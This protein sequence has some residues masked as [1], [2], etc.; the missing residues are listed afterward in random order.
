MPAGWMVGSL[1]D[2]L[3]LYYKVMGKKSREDWGKEGD[4]GEKIAGW[5]GAVKGDASGSFYIQRPPLPFGEK[6]G[7]GSLDME[8]D[9]GG[10]F[11]TNH[12]QH[13]RTA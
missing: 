7:G 1:A 4:F 12:G 5:G 13:I 2:S 8:T 6:R 3:I 9:T 10:L 11:T